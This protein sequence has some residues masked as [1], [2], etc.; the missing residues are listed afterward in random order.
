MLPLKHQEEINNRYL[1]LLFPCCGVEGTPTSL[2]AC[3]GVAGCDLGGAL[4][5]DGVSFLGLGVATLVSFLALGVAAFGVLFV[6]L[7]LFSGG[8]GVVGRGL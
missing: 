6:L 3:L 5:F 4:A 2:L 7:A 8:G 1:D